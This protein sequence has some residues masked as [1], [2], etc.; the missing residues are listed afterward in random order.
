VGGEVNHVEKRKIMTVGEGWAVPVQRNRFFTGKFMS[1]SDFARDQEYFLKR[2]R[3]LSSLSLGPGVIRGLEVKQH[4][5]E[6]H[7][8]RWVVV[9]AG[10]ALDVRGRE[11]ILA[12][13][14]PVEIFGADESEPDPK[15]IVTIGYREE[16][17]TLVP[18]LAGADEAGSA[19]LE[20]GFVIEGRELVAHSEGPTLQRGLG[21]GEL[22]ALGTIS[23]TGTGLEID[24]DTRNVSRSAPLSRISSLSWKHAGSLGA[25]KAL[26]LSI[27]FDAA[28][29]GLPPKE[30]IQITHEIEGRLTVV[31]FQESLSDSADK[32]MLRLPRKTKLS[33]GA[34]VRVSLLCD[35]FTDATGRAID[36]GFVGGRLP[37]G[38]GS[39][40]GRFESW[41][42]IRGD[43]DHG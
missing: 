29:G 43:L 10:W 24:L 32:L 5:N 17:G 42:Q 36:G 15:K 8:S 22:I 19:I 16:N 41:F 13:D 26:N 2:H 35:F 20:P 33:V 30:A 11:L 37:S 12:K 34:L 21:N 25:E 40:G 9:G 3:L 6:N 1:A 7:R 23:A 38:S 4:P 39:P 27:G 18:S 28:L 31:G 14:E